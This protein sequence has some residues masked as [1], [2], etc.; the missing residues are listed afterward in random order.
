[1]SRRR[2]L[3][4]VAVLAVA[5]LVASAQPAAAADA[6]LEVAARNTTDSDFAAG[7]RSDLT[8]AAGDVSLTTGPEPEIPVWRSGT[9]LSYVG[10]EDPG[11]TSISGGATEDG[12]GGVGDVD[13]DGRVE[14]LRFN[15]GS[16]GGGGS[17]G[18]A[19]F[20]DSSGEFQGTTL[21]D[22]VGAI[23]DVDG[24]GDQRGLAVVNGELVLIDVNS[25]S[26]DRTTTGVS[27]ELVGD[28]VGDP[29]SDGLTEIAIVQS[30]SLALADTGGQVQMSPVSASE[31][32]GAA[33]WDDDGVV[34][35]ASK[36]PD[37]DLQVTEADPGSWGDDSPKSGFFFT[38]SIG[39]IADWDGDGVAEAVGTT[40]NDRIFVIEPDGTQESGELG[41]DVAT[42]LGVEPIDIDGDR[43]EDDPGT[44]SL[45]ET[46]DGA[47]AVEVDLSLTDAEA[48]VTVRDGGGT[49]LAQETTTASGTTALAIDHSGTV[50]TE[51]QLSATG[52]SPA[53]TLSEHRVMFGAARPSGSEPGPTGQITSYDGDISLQVNDSD[54]GLAQGDSVTVE[55][56]NS[57][58]GTIGQTTVASNQT[59]S[60][61][62]SALAG[63]NDVTWTL[64]DSYGTTTTVSQSF[65][66]PAKLRVFNASDPDSLI[67]GTENTITVSFFDESDTVFRRTTANGTVDLSG[68]PAAPEQG[69]QI[70]VE[71]G[72]DFESRQIVIGSLFEQQSVFL[73]PATADTATIE[74]V[75]DDKTGRFNP[76]TTTLL[77]E[78]PINKSGST[79]FQTVFASEVGAGGSQRVVL[80]NGQR[81]RIRVRNTQGVERALG[82]FD[83]SGS[84]VVTLEIG[85]LT[86]AVADSP[87]TFNV[88]ADTTT[89]N[90]TV[91]SAQFEFRDPTDQTSAVRVDFLAAN[92]TTLAS[93]SSSADPVTQFAFTEQFTA[94]VSASDLRI[95]YEIDRGGETIS[96]V[97]RAGASQFSPGIPLKPGLKQ[98]FAV[99]LIIM[100]GGLF[101]QQN[102]AAGAVVTPLFAAGLWFVD[103][104]PPG[105]TILGI[106]LALGVGVLANI[107]TRP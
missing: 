41:D 20:V 72:A 47:E 75:L 98:L 103:W 57:S 84:D 51:I 6:A 11:R 1:M 21:L 101:S 90:G 39:P 2:I 43:H 45:S 81:Y 73:L 69:Y 31:L 18:G 56:T 40:G 8:V 92:N 17:T 28:A 14:V 46:V 86:F 27:A 32:G 25:G 82:S 93:A 95:A 42:A 97:L 83:A 23:A 100:V 78:R 4:I 89:T 16:G 49:Q 52:A 30:G 7:D 10:Y 87:Q 61:G 102:A 62:Y 53:A 66:T 44:I 106:A 33:D 55:A 59:V 15:P 35:V 96:G 67:T 29:D 37:A 34:E 24:D 5:A 80:E 13:D 63:Q 99:G 104:L 105:V 94:N 76:E 68:L 38:A 22:S 64:T 88:S 70:S 60:F 77:L 19:G 91:D 85:E 9:D 74:F 12:V 3:S 26:T 36:R 107:K 58:G 65:T 79:T 71:D 48:T 50:R 54:F